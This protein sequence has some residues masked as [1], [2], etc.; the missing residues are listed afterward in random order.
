[1]DIGHS[2]K[3]DSTA[4]ESSNKEIME[5]RGAPVVDGGQEAEGEADAEGHGDGVLGV[6]GHALEDLAR[7]Y[8]GGDDGRQARLRQHDV[9]SSTGR[10]GCAWQ[11]SVTCNAMC[12]KR[13]KNTDES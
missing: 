6:G 4:L 13:F 2:Q 3:K 9:R 7:A 8:D 10:I 5:S 11:Q 12:R 1:M